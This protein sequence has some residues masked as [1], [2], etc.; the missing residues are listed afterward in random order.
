[1]RPTEPSEAETKR[2]AAVL[3][4][5]LNWQNGFSNEEAVRSLRE[6]KLGAAIV[7]TI[8][9]P[10]VHEAVLKAFR[11]LAGDAAVWDS[12]RENCHARRKGDPA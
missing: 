8:K 12:T 11:N 5:L 9:G 10:R 2:G 3:L 1:M 4:Y 7:S 6:A